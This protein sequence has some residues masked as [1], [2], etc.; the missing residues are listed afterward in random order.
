M[1][2]D[3][4]LLAGVED[5]RSGLAELLAACRH[6]VHLHTPH[7]DPRLYN[8]SQVIGAIRARVSDQPRLRFHLLLPPAA[9]WRG[10]CPSLLNLAERLS[11]ALELRT[12]PADEPRERPEFG[13]AFVIVDRKLLLYQP[14]PRVFQADLNLQ[15]S[16]RARELLDFFTAVWDKSRSDPE[17][18]RLML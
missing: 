17:L 9:A 7:L 8:D 15:G 4:R 5:V 2:G 12:P 13:Q 14:D 11:T 10:G 18:R 3:V 6:T 1:P 16:I